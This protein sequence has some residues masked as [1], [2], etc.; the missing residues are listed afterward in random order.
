MALKR[1][2]QA[3]RQKEHWQPPPCIALSGLRRFFDLQAGTVWNDLVPLLAKAEGTLLDAGCGA[4]PYRPLLPPGVRYIGIDQLSAEADFGYKTPHT[5]Y[6]SGDRWPV[7]NGVADTILA[8]ETLEH[9]RDPRGF[10]AEAFRCVKGGGRLILTVPFSA[11]WHYIPRDYFRYTPSGLNML[12]AESG[13]TDVEIYARGNS[14][15]VASLKCMALAL[16]FLI[17]Q[18]DSLFERFAYM[19]AGALMLPWFLFFSVLGNI[20]L[21]FAGGDDCLGYTAVARKPKS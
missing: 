3:N 4:Q 13:F 11:R 18:A 21:A 16:P 20:S 15:T 6:Y 19:M 5:I 10:I 2:N 12:L 17:P 8:T 1:E 9:V 14:V 7:E